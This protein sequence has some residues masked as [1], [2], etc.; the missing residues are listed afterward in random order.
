VCGEE[1]GEVGMAEEAEGEMVEGGQG[2]GPAAAHPRPPSATRR[3]G[4]AIQL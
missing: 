4:G 1:G 2:P 3:G